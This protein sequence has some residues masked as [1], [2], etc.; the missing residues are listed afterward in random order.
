[1]NELT[2]HE[3]MSGSLETAR[4]VGHQWNE[5]GFSKRRKVLLA[6]SVEL[7]NNLEKVTQIIHEE[8]GKPLSD[9]SLESVAAITHLRWAA[10]NAQHILSRKSR[11]SGLLNINM[12]SRVEFHPYGVVGVIGPWNYPIF[13]P[14]GSISYALAAGNAII[15][16]PSEFTPKIGHYFAQLLNDVSPIPNLIQVLP[17]QPA[18]GAALASSPVDKISFTGSSATGRKV[19][20]AC[21][22]NLTPHVLECGGKDAVIIDRDADISRAADE[23]LW[24]AMS[25]AGQT[26]IGS[27]RV[28]VH[29]EVSE[30]FISTIA[31][32]AQLISS[33]HENKYGPMVMQNSIESIK[34]RVEQAISDGATVVAG[35]LEAF[36][37][38]SQ[39]AGF[40]QPVILRDLPDSSPVMKEEIF[41]PVLVIN[42]VSSIDEAITKANDNPYGLGAS[43]WSRRNGKK[44]A[45]QL[46]SGMVSVNSVLAFA[47]VGS[48]PF[49]GVKASGYGRIHGKEGLKEFAYPHSVVSQNFPLPLA[50]TSFKRTRMADKT[51][52]RII[53]LLTRFN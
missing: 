49:G 27:E 32:A 23:I 19:A 41:G 1:M 14:L 4:Q 38:D 24:A 45:S 44:I 13:T 51:L 52:V 30:K 15:F 34:A 36:T 10:N 20:A 28:Y 53:K 2:P 42:S 22:A 21:A 12:Q 46:A 39:G 8:T 48:L 40:I 17:E 33:S 16:K 50:F 11:P 35:G 43:V 37:R 3:I 26:C 31:Q 5:L 18:F 47:T 29:Q 6:W 9:A 25:N 7:T